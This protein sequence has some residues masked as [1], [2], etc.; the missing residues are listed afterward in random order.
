MK[1]V[2]IFIIG[3]IIV[4]GVLG[5][6]LNTRFFSNDSTDTNTDQEVSQ[7]VTSEGYSPDQ[8]ELIDTFGPPSR[9]SISYVPI[10]EG[11]ETV[12]G[13]WEIWSYPDHQYEIQFLGG[14][15][16]DAYAIDADPTGTVY[17]GFTPNMFEYDMDYTD[18]QDALSFL[19]IEPNDWL[20][21]F[22]EE[23]VIESYIA[24]F[25]TFTIEYDHLTYIETLGLPPL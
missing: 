22:Y 13:R 2:G 12:L 10:G 17:S 1:R 7:E 11:D 24:S 19:E 5:Y 25:V 3:G 15:I 20:P 16:M 23:G 4:L 9:F 8:Q 14:D 21:E 6:L 18:V